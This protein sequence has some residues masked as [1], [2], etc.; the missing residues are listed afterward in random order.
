ML[1]IDKEKLVLNNSQSILLFGIYEQLEEN[2]KLMRELIEVNKPKEVS[3]IPE[4]DIKL[5]EAKLGEIAAQ[6]T[7]EEIKPKEEV[8]TSSTVKKTSPTKS[9]TT[10]TTTANS[11]AAKK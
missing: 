2:N 3:V 1:Q 10:K 8:K 4:T 7:E 9:R 5:T 6:L 11:S